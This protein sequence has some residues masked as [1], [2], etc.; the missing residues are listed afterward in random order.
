MNLEDF[1]QALSTLPSLLQK[2]QSEVLSTAINLSDDERG[3]L[4]KQLQKLDNKEQ[5]NLME[6]DAA[7]Q[8]LEGFLENTEQD[9]KHGEVIESHKTEYKEHDSEL[10]DIESKFD[11]V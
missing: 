10:S 1:T 6:E 9:V 3:S 4:W 5:K 8:K 11:D 7:L 2:Q